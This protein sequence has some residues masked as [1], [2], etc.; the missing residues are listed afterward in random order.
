MKSGV[1]LGRHIPAHRAANYADYTSS[2]LS[3][4]GEKDS[5]KEIGHEAN[6]WLEAK[7][8]LRTYS[9]A[10]LL[11]NYRPFVSSLEPAQWPYSRSSVV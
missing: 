5:N 4:F 10:A 9:T 8:K 6:R 3:G 11:N 2:D 1:I 7:P